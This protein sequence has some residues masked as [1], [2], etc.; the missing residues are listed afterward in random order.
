MSAQSLPADHVTCYR[1]G[2]PTPAAEGPVCWACRKTESETSSD[3]AERTALISLLERQA[4]DVSRI[5][6]YVMFLAFVTLLALMASFF[7]ALGMTQSGGS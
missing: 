3:A 5:K 6:N 1:C 7:T 4:A 2:V